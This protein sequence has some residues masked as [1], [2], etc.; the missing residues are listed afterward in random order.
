MSFVFLLYQVL[1]LEI[2]RN[3]KWC[4]CMEAN[5][6]GNKDRKHLTQ[7]QKLVGKVVTTGS[8]SF[9]NICGRLCELVI[10]S[11]QLR[12]WVFDIYTSEHNHNKNIT[13]N[14]FMQSTIFQRKKGSK[15]SLNSN[16]VVLLMH[17]IGVKIFSNNDEN[18]K[19]NQ[20]VI[21]FIIV[22]WGTFF[23]HVVYKKK[24]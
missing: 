3:L 21:F 4:E 13:N 10:H 12:C 20:V 17:E 9:F 6:N 22:I 19:A 2:W 14:V 24:T 16:D 18:L 1:F 23:H 8:H 15:L 5:I 11:Y 7:M